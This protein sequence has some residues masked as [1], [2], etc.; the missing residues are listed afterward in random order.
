MS[1]AYEDGGNTK[2]VTDENGNATRYRYDAR[3]TLVQVRLPN[4]YTAYYR[5]DGMG[6]L[7]ETVDM[8]NLKTLYRYD[9]AGNLTEKVHPN[10]SRESYTYDGENRLLS[11]TDAKDQTTRY[12]GYDSQ[13]RPKEITY[14][15]GTRVSY[16]Y[17]RG[18]RGTLSDVIIAGADPQRYR[19]SYT[20]MGQ[21]ESE[22]KVLGGETSR[23]EYAWDDTGL[24]LKRRD[25]LS[26]RW[27]ENRY[28]SMGRITGV[29]YEIDGT[30]TPVVSDIVYTPGSQVAGYSLP[31]QKIKY[32]YTYDATNDRML[33]M[34]AQGPLMLSAKKPYPIKGETPWVK[35]GLYLQQ[36]YRYDAAGNMT[37]M[38]QEEW[39]G[40]RQIHHYSYDVIHQLVGYDNQVVGS[41]AAQRVSYTYD[42][43]GNRMV[44]QYPKSTYRHEIANNSNELVSKWEGQTKGSDGAA[45]WSYS[46]D[47]NG[48]LT[49]GTQ[50]NGKETFAKYA[51]T[52]DVKNRLSRFAEN[53]TDRQRNG[54]EF[55]SGLRYLKEDIRF[56]K[57]EPMF[58]MVRQ[59]SLYS[60][61]GE[62]L[63]AEQETYSDHKVTRG[64]VYF[65]NQ[66]VGVVD[67][68]TPLS[69]GLSDRGVAQTP[70]AGEAGT[71]R[72]AATPLRAV[73]YPQV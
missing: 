9:E 2:I 6:K 20:A 18:Y 56:T 40:M 62:Q 33:R 1:V 50:T 60:D 59:R 43:Q 41:T 47:A 17:D 55:E 38:V 35:D 7:T 30:M 16:A 4:V 26:G 46:Y 28:D 3:D 70:A 8:R 58:E 37:E 52:W 14:G 42:P 32:A 19:Y 5:Y 39:D 54:Y 23:I 61:M 51:Y 53:E 71:P 21:R 44:T 72:P 24:L 25:S 36:S 45:W 68:S 63:L 65:G 12:S 11:R 10:G 29:S 13:G 48:N 73:S 34:S 69:A 15:D 66:R 31:R 22:E 49:T 67:T 57:Q 27:Q 64:Y